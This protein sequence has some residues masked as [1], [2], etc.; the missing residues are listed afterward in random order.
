MFAKHVPDFMDLILSSKHTVTDGPGTK[1]VERGQLKSAWGNKI[2]PLGFDR[3]KTCE[4]MAE[5]LHCSNMGLLN[6]R[7]SE[8]YVR[9]RDLERERLRAEGTLNVHREGDSG[10]QYTEASAGF[11]NGVSSPLAGSPEDI[12]RFE[13]ANAGD[14]DGFEDVAASGVLNDEIKDDFDEKCDDKDKPSSEAFTTIQDRPRIDLGDEFMDE[15]LSSPRLEADTGDKMPE[16]D[17]P[18]PLHTNADP[19]SPTTTGL[20]EKVR[21]FSLEKDTPMTGDEKSSDQTSEP[22]EQLQ[23]E[24]GSP[25]GLSPRAEDTPAPLF[26]ASPG[27][28]REEAAVSPK[29]VEGEQ[30]GTSIDIT[31]GEGGD[32]SQSVVM[33][34]NEQLFEPHVETDID[35]KPV[36]GDYL[37]VMFVENRVVPTILVQSDLRSATDNTLT[38]LTELLFPLPL[39]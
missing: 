38:R 18:S 4:L 15:P 25:G 22:K 29:T 3:F 28:S 26:A 27:P 9:K 1:L 2:E 24:A 8:E 13:I 31:L 39:E 20:A 16:E 21:R 11:T 32:S 33:S 34:G 17:A 37:K 7:G 10:V 12:R 36:V 5:L 23:V 19:T 6:E 35:G 14:E 30:S